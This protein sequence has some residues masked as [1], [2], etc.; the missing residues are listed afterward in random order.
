MH[1]NETI[2]LEH[3]QSYAIYIIRK[4]RKFVEYHQ[5]LF[6][7]DVREGLGPRLSVSVHCSGFGLYKLSQRLKETPRTIFRPV[8]RILRGGVRQYASPAPGARSRVAICVA[9]LRENQNW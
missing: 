9:I 7:A 8:R 1:G 3:M 4:T 2:A 6:Q 5:T